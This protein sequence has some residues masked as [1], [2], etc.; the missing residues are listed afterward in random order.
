[1]HAH[2]PAPQA[3]ESEFLWLRDGNLPSSREDR[4][5]EAIA[6]FA[7]LF[8]LGIGLVIALLPVSDPPR[9]AAQASLGASELRRVPV[10]TDG[11]TLKSNSGGRAG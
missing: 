7:L 10:S 5:A 9:D 11:P 2:H 8:S 3:P 4:V 1:M 6:L